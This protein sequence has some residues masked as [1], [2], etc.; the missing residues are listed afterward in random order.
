ML[1]YDKIAIDVMENGF[2]IT[3]LSTEDKD[4]KFVFDDVKKMKKWIEENLS[5]TG[6][7]EEFS[8]ALD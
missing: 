2:I 1:L 7:V 3:V 8:D 6:E 4:K 5:V